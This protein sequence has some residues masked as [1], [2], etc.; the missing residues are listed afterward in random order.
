M[1]LIALLVPAF[2]ALEWLPQSTIAD[3]STRNWVQSGMQDA[4]VECIDQNS[5]VKRTDGYTQYDELMLYDKSDTSDNDVRVN[6]VRCDEDMSG[7]TLAMKGRPFH[8]GKSG[9]Y[10]W[11]D[12]PAT[13]SSSLSGQSAKFVCKK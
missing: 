7:P 3:A 5:I 13:D 2:V 6:A 8:P 4:L 1:K 9:S 10:R 11:V 12:E